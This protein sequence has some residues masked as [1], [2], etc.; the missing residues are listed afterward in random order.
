[1][2]SFE[3]RLQAAWRSWESQ[4]KLELKTLKTIFETASN[5]LIHCLLKINKNCQ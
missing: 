3:F 2:C 1:M 5:L 4:L